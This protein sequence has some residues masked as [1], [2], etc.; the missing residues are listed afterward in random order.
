[1][2]RSA[3]GVSL[4]L[5]TPQENAMYQTNVAPL[6]CT[7]V[8]ALPFGLI[9][10]FNLGFMLAALAD[11]GL[12]AAFSAGVWAFVGIGLLI[13]MVQG[14]RKHRDG[15]APPA[16]PLPPIFYVMG[17]LV[18]VN[19]GLSASQTGLD[20]LRA[21]RGFERSVQTV[22]GAALPGPVNLSG[23]VE[24]TARDSLLQSPETNTPVVYYHHLVER[25][26]GDSWKIV[27]A[28]TRFVPFYLSD[29][30]GRVR[31]EP[32]RPV[33]FRATVDHQQRRGEMRHT[34][35]RIH[36]G[37]EVAV[38][39]EAL[40]QDEADHAGTLIVTF[41][42]DIE[43]GS[44]SQ[45][46]EAAVNFGVDTWGGIHALRSEPVDAGWVGVGSILYSWAGIALLSLSIALLFGAF[47]WHNSVA[48]LTAVV[49][50]MVAA[51][52]GQSH[53]MLRGD[54][55]QTRTQ[56]V[57]QLEMAN[58][59]IVAL[60]A[61]EGDENRI[62]RIRIDAARAV[63]H[64]NFMLAGFPE[65]VLAPSWGFEPIDPIRLS[66]ADAREARALRAARPPAPLAEWWVWIP[67]LG[68]LL[69]GFALAY[70]GLRAV[71]VKRMIENIPT[72][73][74]QSVCYGIAEVA[75]VAEA[76]ASGASP[77]TLSRETACWYRYTIEERSESN[78]EWV[79]V[80]RDE[81]VTPFYC[82]DATGRI[83]IWP[84]DAEVITRHKTER[85]TQ[86]K[87]GK[88]HTEYR[89]VPGDELYV[90][91]FA[92]VDATT[93]D[94]LV[95]GGTH[96]FDLP[97]IVSTQPEAAVLYRKGA[98]G[99]WLL[100]G[101]LAGLTLA[102]LFGLAATGAYSPAGHMAAVL[103][104]WVFLF[105]L[106]G[107]LH[108]ND[109]VFLR[110]RADRNRAN[111][112]VALKKR[113][114]LT[115]QLEAVVRED[116]AHERTLLDR[117]AAMRSAAKT[118]QEPPPEPGEQVVRPLAASIRALSEAYPDLQSSDRSV[119]LMKILSRL[120]DEVALMRD[121][122]NDAVERFNTRV[123]SL[124]DILLARPFGFRPRPLLLI[125]AE[126]SVA[127]TPAP[128]GGDGGHA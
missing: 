98:L 75:G 78:R 94:R 126:P 110:H 124:P 114:D 20:G 41:G 80:H 118:P 90:L 92:G 63:D 101:S 108:Y 34:E 121:G 113:L 102:A 73:P 88:R 28:D 71:S 18:L 115:G 51:L 128:A 45:Q 48:Y 59:R 25:R 8:V 123:Q 11:G 100:N 55:D 67:I 36:P 35:L 112:D 5:A 2:C 96:D 85:E 16:F 14:H 15:L 65:R 77:A 95:L 109:L 24:A 52:T 22:I 97:F 39:G 10:L 81:T 64:Y 107:V 47:R 21:L 72:S 70:G 122:Y 29:G 26:S 13:L 119:D 69:A 53:Y 82:A 104:G 38:L 111:I 62:R 12:M 76:G 56:V 19:F 33:R 120:E 31:V 89:V 106:V 61:T 93:G 44:I 43:Q 105:L 27:S 17:F 7:L 58:Q 46:T 50:V 68:G 83:E 49:V 117:I 60:A 79:E 116:L 40:R 84:G 99:R 32:G 91:G 37:D 54:L 57:H 3:R 9:G 1:M 30:T 42:G 86:G 125:E 103:V 87:G 66:E 127:P 74:V 4:E 6:G 23:T